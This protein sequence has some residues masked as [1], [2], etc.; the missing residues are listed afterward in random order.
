MVAL[1][2]YF[3]G[4]CSSLCRNIFVNRFRQLNSSPSMKAL[5]FRYLLGQRNMRNQVTESLVSEHVPQQ[6]AGRSDMVLGDRVASPVPY[7]Y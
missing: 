5:G 7:R 3:K 1:K 6:L 4:L 2:T